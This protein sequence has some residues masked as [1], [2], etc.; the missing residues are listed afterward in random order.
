MKLEELIIETLAHKWH[1]TSKQR[2][3]RTCPFCWDSS[4]TKNMQFDC[5]TCKC[6]PEICSSSGKDG[7]IADLIRIYGAECKICEIDEKNLNK[8]IGMFEKYL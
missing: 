4:D 2:I 6:P 3:S 7:F 5:N 8:M 1:K